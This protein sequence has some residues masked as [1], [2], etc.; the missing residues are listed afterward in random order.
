MPNTCNF[1]WEARFFST[2]SSSWR[3]LL[4]DANAAAEQ[5]KEAS[6][7]KIDEKV[8]VMQETPSPKRIP[9][10]GSRRLQNT[11]NGLENL[12]L[13]SKIGSIGRRMMRR[14]C[15]VFDTATRVTQNEQS[16]F[17]EFLT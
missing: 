4:Q 9:F 2:N 14:V 16:T 10:K 12:A 8:K 3:F 17:L 5:K 13:G 6:K 11:V 1:L 7:K 15:K